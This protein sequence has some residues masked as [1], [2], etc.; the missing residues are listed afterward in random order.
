MHEQDAELKGL[1]DRATRGDHDALGGLLDHFRPQLRDMA[2]QSI[3]RAILARTDES[4]VVQHSCLSAIEDFGQFVGKDVAQ[5]AVWVRQ[6]HE[7]NIRNTIR[8]HAVSQKRAVSREVSADAAAH[9][10]PAR[11]TTPSQQ[12]IKGERAVQITDA[13]A[14]LPDG[15]REAVRLRYLEGCSLL[16]VA[17]LLG[18]TEDSVAGLLKRG[19]ARLREIVKND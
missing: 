11:I 3:D 14:Q 13:V 7:R 4:D 17:E 6:I 8:D 19:L 15:Q 18:R 10:A 16:Q 2:R 12:A 5:F 9:G 1:L